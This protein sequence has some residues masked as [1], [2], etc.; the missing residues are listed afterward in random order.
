METE[1]AERRVATERDAAFTERFSA[2][3]GRLL[4][5]CTGLVGPDE[6]ED[7]LH[8]AY[9]RG[10]RQAHTLRDDAAF[11]PWLTRIAINLCYSRHHRA[12]TLRDLL[13]QIDRRPVEQSRDLA[14]RDLV[15]RLPPRERTVLILHYGHGYRLEEIAQLLDLT[16]VNV[17][18]IVSRTRRKL[19]VQ[20]RE[21]RDG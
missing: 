20:W 6:A 19:A 3:R 18:A 5:I 2:L 13:P 17:R 10:M 8:D 4:A 14:L 16:A 7:V 11:E 21:A 15:E 1:V 9:L 12:R